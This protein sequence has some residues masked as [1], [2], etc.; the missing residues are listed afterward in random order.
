VSL[1][2]RGALEQMTALAAGALVTVQARAQEPPL[3]AP[4]LPPALPIAPGVGGQGTYGRLT[5]AQAAA[6]ALNALGTRCVYGVPG[7]Q[8]NEFWDAMKSRGVPYLLVTN[9]ASASVMADACARV[10]GGV[11]VFAV[12]PGPGL[13]NA[14]TG[15]GEARHDS[16]PI[17]G[18]VTDILR[19][20][21]AP[22]GQV[23]GVANAAL[24]RPLCKAVFELTHVSEIPGAIVEAHRL[25]ACGE[26]GPAAVVIPYS[27]FMDMWKYELRSCVHEPTACDEHGYRHALRLLADRR[28]RVGIYAGMGTHGCTPELQAVAELLQA[29]VATSVS[30]KG[31]ISDAHP[32]AVGWGYGAYGTRTAERAFRDVDLVLAVGVKYS[33][34]STAN[35]ATPRHSHVIH[36]DANPQNI[37]RNLPTCVGVASDAGIFLQRLVA[38]GDALRRSPCPALWERIASDRQSERHANWK[39]QVRHGVDPMLLFLHLRQQMCPDDLLFVD[40]TA[41]V[42]WASEAF[43][44]PGPRRFFTPTDNQS[45]GWAVPAAIGAQRV[46]LDHRAVAVTGD[47][48]FLMSGLEASTAA[49]VCLPVKIFILDDGAY[50]YM[51]MLQEPAF[52]R[53]TATE[54]ARLDFAALAQGLNLAY[55]CIDHNEDIAHG[56]ARAFCHPGPILTRVIVGYD[57]RPIRWLEALKDSY[58]DGMK[59]RQKVRMAS[60]IAV[61]KA[62]PFLQD[63]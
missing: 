12:V 46:C 62:N 58:I 27:L 32:L 45:M 7:A 51:Q 47:G 40:V 28:H 63:D 38:D 14:L 23:H 5:G 21:G 43:D 48:C 56:I 42:H 31:A 1:N 52:G 4:G 53:T 9:E 22:N 25:A 2:R 36:V 13:T 16:V 19:H 59:S 55:N 37:G 60:R 49:R 50:H 15:I 3:P 24:L 30:G 54:I 8:N 57:G 11:G 33:E 39:A 35:Y 61:R 17:V 34:V 29:P 26:P 18:L 41:S 20:P 10:T 44:V 6:E